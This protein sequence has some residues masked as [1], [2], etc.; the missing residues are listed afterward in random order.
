MQLNDH[1]TNFA[2]ADKFC[3]DC[4]GVVVINEPDLFDTRFGIPVHYSSAICKSCGLEQLAP[5]PQQDELKQLYET[6][7]NFGGEQNTRYTFLRERF[8]LSS[9]YHLWLVLD[10][11]ISFHGIKGSGRLLDVGCNEGRGLQFYQRNGWQAEGLELNSHAAATARKLGYIVHS[12][13]IEDFVPAEKYDVVVLSNVLEHSLQ[14][15]E[16]LCHIQ[17]LLRPGGQVWISCP[18]GESIVRK[19]FGRFWINWHVPFHIVQF[20]P[21]TLRGMLKSTGFDSVVVR[22]ETPALWVAHSLISRLYARPGRVTR[23]LRNPALVASM[24]LGIRV[25]LFPLLWMANRSGRGDCL[26]VRATLP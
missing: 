17:R 19:I 6:Y 25:L 22:Q 3:L 12:E 1:R 9:L 23:Q 21:R 24:I 13:L 2:E 15:R 18:N 10:G 4:A 8:H 5:P 14:P 20:S 16:M 7:Y 26:V 11:D